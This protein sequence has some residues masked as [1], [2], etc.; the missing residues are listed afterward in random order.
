[1]IVKSS[2]STCGKP[3]H[4]APASL[5]LL[6]LPLVVMLGCINQ[7]GAWRVGEGTFCLLTP[8]NVYIARLKPSGTELLMLFSIPQPTPG[9]QQ[10]VVAAAAGC[11]G[12]SS[13]L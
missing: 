1:M 8:T 2:T 11:G 6:P 13:R 5:L 3:L 9:Q 4:V 12:S 7:D 10:V